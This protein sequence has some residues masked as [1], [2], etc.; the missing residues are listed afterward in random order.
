MEGQVG[1]E[2][3]LGARV[4]LVAKV[5]LLAVVRR[6]VGALTADPAVAAELRAAADKGGGTCIRHDCGREK[7]DVFDLELVVDG[8][9]K[10]ALDRLE[11]VGGEV[12]AKAVVEDVEEAISEVLG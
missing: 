3:V 7:P 12:L 2:G 1:L 9:R 4:R 6:I 5:N 11:D 10:E 8:Q